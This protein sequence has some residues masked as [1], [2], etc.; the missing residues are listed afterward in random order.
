MNTHLKSILLALVFS[1]LFFAKDLGLNLFILSL[2]ISF[3]LVMNTLKNKIPWLFLSA[4][5]LS[6][7]FVFIHPSSLTSFAYFVALFI[8]IGKTA[9]QKIATP[10]AGLVGLIS[11]TSASIVN[12]IHSE[13]SIPRKKNTTL[14]LYGKGIVIALVFV[15]LFTTLYSKAN[16]IFNELLHKI[17]L[18]F[19][20]IN[21]LLLTA[22]GYFIFLHLL[23]PYHSHILIEKDLELG[24]DLP[25]PKTTFSAV[26]IKKLGNEV[27]IASIV[28]GALNL[29]L[30]VF[31]VTDIIYL[32][33]PNVTSESQ[34]SQS[35]HQG[36]YALLVSII[37]AIAVILYYFRGNLNFFIKN[38]SLKSLSFLWIA[39]NLVLTTTT[40]YKNYTYVSELGFT[41][42]RIGVFIYLLLII[43]GLL[44]V[45]IKISKQKNFLFLLRSNTTIAFAILIFSSAIPWD[46]FITTFNLAHIENPDVNY[47]M[48]LD[49]SNSNYLLKYATKNANKLTPTEN[50]RILKRTNRYTNDLKARVWQEYTINNFI[51]NK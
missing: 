35:V 25:K 4:F 28:L 6:G 17:N 18:S 48:S 26:L 9:S 27:T 46:R 43:G 12:T 31:L 47:L 1:L 42:K 16:P 15:F 30:L 20:S 34:Y 21:W 10:I 2:L 22:L 24:D 41:Y 38:K 37:C 29:L 13:K 49:S 40:F 11:I 7:L 5:I 8:L 51:K 50:D 44:T 23:R 33:N 32:S 19:I 45:G 3:I 36:V 39:L 14:I